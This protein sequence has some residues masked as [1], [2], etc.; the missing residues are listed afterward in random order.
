LNHFVKVSQMAISVE[1]AVT[2]VTCAPLSLRLPRTLIFLQS[3]VAVVAVIP[4][5]ATK[6]RLQTLKSGVKKVLAFYH[7]R[8]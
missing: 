7:W 3:A 8:T 1:I 4:Y 2:N 6:G 5:S